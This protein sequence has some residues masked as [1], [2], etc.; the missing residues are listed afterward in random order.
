MVRVCESNII[1]LSVSIVRPYVRPSRY[2]LL[3]HWA[4]L[5]YGPL[6]IYTNIHMIYGKLKIIESNRLHKSEMS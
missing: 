3:N 4:I 1:F 6:N 2:P 5:P